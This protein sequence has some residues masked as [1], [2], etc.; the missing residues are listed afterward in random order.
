MKHRRWYKKAKRE[1]K[2]AASAR[3]VSCHCVKYQE[4][5][6]ERGLDRGKGIAERAESKEAVSEAFIK[7]ERP[8]D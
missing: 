1:K 2:A 5:G 7:V 8:L 6:E 4:G 3:N